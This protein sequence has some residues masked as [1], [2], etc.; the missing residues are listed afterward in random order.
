[1]P[2]DINFSKRSDY[3]SHIRKFFLFPEFWNDPQKD[4]SI[5][6]NSWHFVK[7]E[8]N[9]K[10]SVPQKKGIYAFVL[11]PSYPS[12]FETNYL[13]YVGKTSRTLQK[14]FSEYF[15]E[16]DKNSKYR[17]M[18]REFLLRYKGHL[19]FYYLELPTSSNIDDSEEKL[20]NTFVPFVNTD[21]PEARIDPNL[22]NIYKSY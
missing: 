2:L 10:D 18:V 19:Y 14:R 17:Y 20:L 13:F 6:P 15:D 9:E 8:E 3:G 12:L 4:I 22:Q 11:K 5:N 7:F 21:I 1:M 16:R